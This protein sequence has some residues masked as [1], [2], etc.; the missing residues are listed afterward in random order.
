M[1]HPGGISG[2][3]NLL[4]L[5]TTVG[6]VR[7]YIKEALK[8]YPCVCDVAGILLRNSASSELP[9][10]FGVRLANDT[11]SGQVSD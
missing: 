5:A 6:G 1:C 9:S 11:M 7:I 2:K 8:G 4:V 10:C 3:R